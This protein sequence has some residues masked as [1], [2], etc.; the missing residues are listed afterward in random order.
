MR[1]AKFLPV[2]F[3]FFY[4]AVVFRPFLLEGKLPIPADTIVGMYH[5]WRDFFKDK[6]PLGIPFKNFQIT[7]SVRQQ[8]PWRELAIE[9]V[10]KGEWPLWNPYSFSGTPLLAN[11]QSAVFYPLNFLYWMADFATAWGI[12]ILLQTVLGGLFL[13][14][15]LFNLRL[16]PLASSLGVISWV[17]SGFFVAWLEWNTTVQVVL[18]L[19]LILLAIDKIVFSEK[20][21]WWAA[22]FVLALSSSFFAGYLQPFF[23]VAVVSLVYLLARLRQTRTYRL[24]PIFFILYSIFLLATAVQWRP[25]LEFIPLSGREIDQANWQR[26]D[27]F[28]PWQNLAQFVAPDFFGN[29]AT[30]NYFGIW[31]YQEFVGYIGIMGLLMAMNAILWRRDKKTLFFLGLLGAALVFALPTPLAKLPF[32]LNLPFIA[33]AQPSRLMLVIDFSLAVLAALGLD[34]LIRQQNTQRREV[35]GVVGAIGVGLGVLWVAAFQFGLEVSQRNLVLPTLLWTGIGVLVF[36]TGFHPVRQRL[37]LLIFMLLVLALFDLSRFAIK[38]LPFSPREYL[39]PPTRIISFL[40]DKAKTHVFR[41]AALDDRILPP[42]FS[43]AYRVQAVSG[44]DPLYLRRYAE[45]IAAMERGKPDISVPFGFNRIIVPKNYS[46]KLFDLLGV[47]YLL[48]MND[49]EDPRYNLVFKEEETRLY[50]ALETLPRAFFVDRVV[51]VTDREKAIETMFEE[52]FPASQSA[53]V[54]GD[55]GN[56]D[57]SIHHTGMVQIVSY[58]EN[59]IVLVTES[60]TGG[61]V[62]LLDSYYPGWRGSIDGLAAKIYVTD[63]TFRGVVVPKGTHTVRFS[64]GL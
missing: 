50:E 61:L 58:A 7:D 9:M 33:T 34:W 21:W 39:Y 28:L 57:E 13:W 35:L 15:F 8:Y 32:A 49:I 44:Y 26:P 31:N 27:W 24:I 5:P 6:Y 20:K 53:V 48:A 25:T 29:P 1:F 19:P 38:F 55:I 64:Y 56:Y 16:N 10:K 45:F 41:V 47:K 23:Y 18:W 3:L 40:Q 36:L 52:D 51:F 2:I 14:L 46:S 30:L 37:G 62:V 54:E 4:T 63:Y 12:Q 11:L 43:T 42:N 22:L 59:E 60:E 17:G